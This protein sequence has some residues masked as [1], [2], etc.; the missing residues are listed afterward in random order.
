MAAGLKRSTSTT[1]PPARST[2]A[3][4]PFNPNTW[5]MGSAPS[6][7]EDGPSPAAGLADLR[8]VHGGQVAVAQGHRVRSA[9]ARR[10]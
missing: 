3:T 4:V 10:W 8:L 6:A 2:V 7:T 9:G 1:Q 5:A